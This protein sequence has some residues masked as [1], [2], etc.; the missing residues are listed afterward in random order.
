M[1]SSVLVSTL[2]AANVQRGNDPVAVLVLVLA[3]VPEQVHDTGH[4]GV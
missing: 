4:A 2:D 1:L 3:R